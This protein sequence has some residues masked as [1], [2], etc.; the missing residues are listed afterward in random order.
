MRWGAAA[1]KTYVEKQKKA[2]DC[3]PAAGSWYSL[4]LAF[5]PQ[6]LRQLRGLW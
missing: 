5:T 3:T 6:A 1:P 4:N 2:A